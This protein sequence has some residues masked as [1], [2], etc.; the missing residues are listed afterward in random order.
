MA[1]FNKTTQ[2]ASLLCAA[3]LMTASGLHTPALA[4]NNSAK[5]C[6][7]G[8]LIG[9]FAI[10]AH[11]NSK[12]V[13]KDDGKLRAT[14][15]SQPTSTSNKG[16]YELYDLSG[17]PGATNR[18]VALRSTRNPNKWWRVRSNNHS[19]KLDNY[20]CRS[21]RTSTTFIGGGT[22][23]AMHLQ[24][25][26]NDQWIYVAGNGKLKAA[27]DSVR[28]D[29]YFK[30]VP[31]GQAPNPDPQPPTPDPDPQPPTPAPPRPTDLRGWWKDDNGRYFHISTTGNNITMKGFNPSGAPLSISTGLLN[32][33]LLS[34][35][36]NNHCYGARGTFAYAYQNGD[37]EKV[38][39]NQGAQRLYSINAP[40]NI[41]LNAQPSCN[42]PT[43]PSPEAATRC[44]SGTLLGRYTLKSELNNKYV[45]A[46]I[47]S[48]SYVGAKSNNVGGNTSWETFDIYDLGNRD[49]LNG[50][51]Y[52]L[53]STQDPNR[54][55][56]VNSQNAL[57][58]M[59]GCTTRSKNRLFRANRISNILQ[60]QSL[61]NQ[62]WVIQRSNN[63]LYANA[64]TAGGNV[65]KALQY[66]LTR[67]GSG[68][69]PQ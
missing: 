15:H 66:K 40:S 34:G 36:W 25:R 51:T 44:D 37:L 35:N 1:S 49:G 30:L 62:Q 13:K 57:K 9:T 31:I 16:V 56:S 20:Q 14:K 54:W 65:P 10:Q 8:R 24:S 52:A 41:N 2:S 63:M 4:G 18:T 47:G 60:L 28:N 53:R 38:D 21:D 32:G 48:G 12:F 58:L 39:G 50:G 5:N 19:V 46:G 3:A 23:S 33:T 17:M 11:S 22:Y 26:K 68:P 55:V 67:I 45:R 61:F 42:T 6:E 27:S 69:S 64:P 43:P 29:S 7:N 59:H